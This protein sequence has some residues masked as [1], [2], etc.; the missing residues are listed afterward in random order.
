MSKKNQK[1]KEAAKRKHLAQS[2]LGDVGLQLEDPLCSIGLV[3]EHIGLSQL[4]IEALKNIETISDK[5]PGINIVLFVRRSTPSIANIIASVFPIRDV[6]EWDQPIIATNIQTCL[7]AI[8]SRAPF[9]YHYV[10]DLDFINNLTIPTQ[11]IKQTFNDKRIRILVRSQHYRSIIENEFG[12]Q[13]VDVVEN[14]DLRK[15]VK[16]IV[17]DMKNV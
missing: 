12:V 4:A 9:V 3:F 5:Y 14:F 2:T 7:D 1:H 8:N 11:D 17:G 6:V 13:V 16:V 15:I 10:Y